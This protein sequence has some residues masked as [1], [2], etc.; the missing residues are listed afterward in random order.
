[1]QKMSHI[2][3]AIDAA[4]IVLSEELRQI[5]KKKRIIQSVKNCQPSYS[6]SIWVDIINSCSTFCGFFHFQ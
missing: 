6:R 5:I 1:M 2:D 3:K 4:V